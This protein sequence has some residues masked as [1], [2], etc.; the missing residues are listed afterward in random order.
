MPPKPQSCGLHTADSAARFFFPANVWST[1]EDHEVRFIGFVGI[2]IGSGLF[3]T[4]RSNEIR[5][6]GESPLQLR[7]G[8]AQVGIA[9][10]PANFL[11]RVCHPSFS[12]RHSSAREPHSE[13]GSGVI[14]V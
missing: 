14:P 11:L 13:S 2:C 5:V 7:V 9:L 6:N 12:T 8:F 1:V 10:P 3:Q 4:L